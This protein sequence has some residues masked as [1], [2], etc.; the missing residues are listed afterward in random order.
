MIVRKQALA[1]VGAASLLATVPAGATAA[2]HPSPNGRCSININVQ[3]PRITAGD[4]VVI[5]GRLRCPKNANQTVRLFRVVRGVPRS[6][7]VGTTKT[8]PSGFFEFQRA[9][10]VVTTNRGWF[11]RSRGAQSGRRFIRVAAQVALTGPSQSELLTGPAH[12][13]TFTGLVSPADV[14]AR[15]ILQRQNATTGGDDW[16]RIN[17]S[18]PDRNVRVAPGGSFSLTHTF[19]VP[20]DAN[21]RVLVRSQGRNVPSPSNVLTYVISQAQNPK[22]TINPSADPISAGQ[23]VTIS[24]TLANGNMQ[25]VTLLA[26]TGSQPFGAIAQTTTDSGGNYTFPA[27]SPI[28]NTV[29]KVQGGGISSAQL[30]EGVK[31]VLIATAVPT[32]VEAGQ[33]VTFS[34]TVTPDHTGHVIYLERLNAN[35]GDFHVVEVARVGAGSAYS[36]MHRFYDAGTKVVRVFIPG[37]PENQGAASQTFNIQVTPAPAAALTPAPSSNSST[38]PD[39]QQ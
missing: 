20:G 16:R 19:V 34:G 12:R 36:F 9:D 35:S 23:S 37:G 29:Y 10:G 13:V 21:I 18:G 7:P 22:L 27:Q 5:F 28:R 14:G 17:G 8:D 32:T 33:P 4:A 1:L 6:V 26:R 24:G 30:Y 25:P 11:V 2:K 39:G 3:P 31:D 38:P 15:V